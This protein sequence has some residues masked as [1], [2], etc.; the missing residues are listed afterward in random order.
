MMMSG[1]NYEK[2]NE[3]LRILRNAMVP[4]IAQE[5]KNVYKEDW[6]TKG[7]IDRL[8]DDQKRNLSRSGNEQE[9]LDSLDPFLA[10]LLFDIHWGDIFRKKLSMDYRNWAKETT[11]TRNKVSHLGGKDFNDDDTFRA[12][13]TIARLCDAFDTVS[14]DKIRETMR[15]VRYGSEYGSTSQS[16]QRSNNVAT[17]TSQKQKTS[18][19]NISGL[20][21]WRDLIEPHPD[22]AQGRYRNAEFAADLAQ[23]ARGEGAYEYRDPV[24][25]F[26]RTFLTEGMSSLLVQ[27]LKRVGGKDGEPVVQLKTAFGG[28]KTHS[29]LALYHL[30]RGRITSER[31]PALKQIL[32]HAGLPSLPTAHVAVLVGT[33]LDVSKTRRPQNFPGITINTIW[34]EMTAQLAEACG[35]PEV[36]NLIKESDRKGVSPGSV[37]LKKI[38]DECG[39]SVVLMDELVAYGKKLYGA[40]GLPAGTYDN[41]IT[42]IQEVTEAARASRNSLVVASIPESEIEVG[43]DAGKKVLETIEHTFGRLEAIW[44]P[45]S[46][47]EGFE[48][49]RRRLFLDCKDTAKRDHVCN[50]FAQQYRNS[51]NDFP[52]EC[53]ELE[54]QER[55]KACYPIHPEIFDRLYEDWS[56]LERFQRTRGVLR[57]MAAVI[58]E[59][60]MQN[61]ASPLIMPGSLPLYQPSIRDELTRH[62]S[63]EW[64]SIVETEV[65][66]KK[67]IP[68]IKEKDNPRYAKNMAARRVARTVFLGSAPKDRSQSTRGI[69]TANIRLGIVVPGESIADFNDALNTLQT[70]LSYLYSNNSLSRFWFDTRPTL[71]KTVAD[72]AKLVRDDEVEL[73]IGKRLRNLK[74]GRDFTGLHIM[75]TTSLDVSDEDSVRLVILRPSSLYDPNQKNCEAIDITKDILEHRGSAP[76]IYKNTLAFIAPDRENMDSLRNEIRTYLAWTS[77][78]NDK[79]T[80]NLDLSQ[81]NEVNAN[82]TRIDKLVDKKIKETYCWLITPYI[83]ADTDIRSII[84]DA[85]RINYSDESIVAEA[86]KKMR[87][88]QV[89]NVDWAPILLKMELEKYYWKDLDFISIKDLWKNL[90]SYCYHQRLLDYSVL[91]RTIQKGIKEANFFALASGYSDGKYI[92]LRLNQEVSQIERQSDILVKIDVAQEQIVKEHNAGV[93]PQGEQA[94]SGHHTSSGQQT[95]SQKSVSAAGTSQT[96]SSAKPVPESAPSKKRVYVSADISYLRIYKDVEQVVK[97]V[98][99]HIK[100]AP[101][102][103]FEIKLEVSAETPNGFPSDVI[104]IVTENCKTLGIKNFGFEEK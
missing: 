95:P 2:I 39:P 13:D 84:W 89:L 9:L 40:V 93:L 7:V 27:A 55:L 83:D 67:S 15:L 54:Y 96:T 59:L 65:D 50:S 34:G 48:V 25:F 70:S 75:P 56:T 62:L 68:L 88:K 31:F 80:L 18:P 72:R 17:V 44:K 86:A 81:V 5:L 92:G 8:Y 73:E 30:L 58:H 57:L 49:V 11:G 60:W 19:D 102:V 87:S 28:G 12:L 66:G 33:A 91:E 1:Q 14:A 69:E 29:L 20:P 74:R 64:N 99:E 36:Y 21:S 32:E 78:N 41:F 101:G 24:E 22:V 4:Y 79:E 6:W 38:F 100:S 97:E 23:V 47:K 103:K 45:V 42:F 77:I 61:D 53:R 85:E 98:V 82:I 94:G 52:T 16:A 76:R 90:C 46:S 63:D 71:R 37:T 104:S 35:K 26:A 43:G 51:P 10:L 3:A